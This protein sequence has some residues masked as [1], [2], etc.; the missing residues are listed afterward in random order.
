MPRPPHAHP[1]DGILNRPPDHGL[2]LAL[3]LQTADP[4]S[5][6]A[7][8]EDLRGLLHHELRSQ[9]DDTNPHSPKDQPSAEPGELG[10]ASGFDRYHLTITVGFA[11]SAYDQLGV[12]A[13]QQPQDL[14][15]ID[16]PS[17]GDQSVRVPANGDVFVQ[18][19]T[20]SMYI[21]EHVQ[22][23]VEEEL[24]AVLA[25]TWVV[26]GAQRHN[27]RS[28]RVNREEGRALIGFKDGT[29]NLD[30]RHDPADATLVFVDPDPAVIAAYPPRVP[31]IGPSNPYGG[32]QPPSFPPDLHDPPAREPDWCCGGSYAV[33]RASTID[34]TTWDDR[35]LGDQERIVGRWKVSGSALDKLDDP[36][37]PPADPDFTADPSGATTPVTAHIRKA[38]P[39]GPDDAARR[40]FRRGYPLILANVDRTLRGLVFVAFARTITTQFE[41]A[42]RAW[43]ANPDFPSPGAGLDAL[44]AFEAVLCGG[45]FFVPPLQR[46]NQP[47]S[48]VIP[49]A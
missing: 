3:T 4:A 49:A 6:R 9:L 11:K 35:A 33:V 27:S 31:A 30:P 24:G 42:T 44:R 36:S 25:V 39:R 48:W 22:R 43:T 1:Q 18:V 8:V 23:R 46:A 10:F 17:L 21:A 47:W 29:S 38:N 12:P 14:R 15:P 2:F 20:D 26:A 32:L 41:F 40:L 7:A 34:T 37:V 13:D 19:C 45:Y 16:W 28:G 5:S